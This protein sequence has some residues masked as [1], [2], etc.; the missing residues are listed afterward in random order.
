MAV[1]VPELVEEVADRIAIIVKGE[2][3]ESGTLTEL[4]NKYKNSNSLAEILEDIV[5]PGSKNDLQAFLNR[6]GL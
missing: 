6:R 5:R 4:K 3:V 1:P 2:I